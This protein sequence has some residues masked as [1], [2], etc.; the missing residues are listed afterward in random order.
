MTDLLILL[1]NDDGYF[2]AGLQ[3]LSDGVRNLG[4]IVTVAPDREKSATSLSLTLRRPLRIREAGPEIYSVDG[5]PADCVYMAVQKILPR[6]PDLLLSGINHGPNLGRQD[7]AYS[8]TVAGALQGSF[9]GI[10]SAAFSLHTDVKGFF[11]FDHAARIA[12]E[13]A[14]RMTAMTFAPGSLLNV[15]IPP[16]PVKGVRITS[17]GQK[18]YDPQIIE[19]HDPRGASYF[20]IGTGRPKATGGPGSDIRAVAQG[21]VSI[22]PLQTDPTD[23]VLAEN[24]R[25]AGTFDGCG[26]DSGD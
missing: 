13:I 7:I 5:T 18:R 23:A 9:L 4:R 26:C 17:L 14:L 16:L 22:T 6:K 15:N 3:A 12:R 10:P 20:W 19:K 8:G 2:S 24:L 11:S 25:N 21:F 1:T